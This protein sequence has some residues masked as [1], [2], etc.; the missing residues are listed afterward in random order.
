MHADREIHPAARRAA[1]CLASLA[2]AIA[3]VAC[4]GSGGGGS[5]TPPAGTTNYTVGVTVN[6]VGTGESFVFSLA[7]QNVSV[8]QGGVSVKFAQA[9]ATGAS[10]TVNQT[11]GPRTCTLSANRTGAIAAANVEV[12][13]NCGTVPGTSQLNGTLRGPVGAQVV[14]QNNGG[15]NLTATVVQSAGVTDHYD[16]TAF[17]FPTLLADGTAYQVSLFTA[18]ANQTCSV[19]KGASGTVPVTATALRVGC[20]FTY[21]HISRSGNDAVRGTYFESRDPVVGGGNVAIGATTQGY[22]E[23]RFVA[24]VSSAVGLAPGAVSGR[25]QIYWRDNLTGETRLV[26]ATA[27]GVEGNG[28]S[29]APAIS[30]DG[31]AVAFESTA[32]N[33][34]AGDTNGVSDIF[35]WSAQDPAGGVERLSVGPNGVQADAASYEPTVSG[36]GRVVA[37]SSGASNLT[38]GV[39]GINTINVYRRDVIAGTNTLISANGAGTGV[40]GSKPAL[41]EDGQRLAFYSFASN[42]TAGDGNGLWDIFVYDHSNGT[43]TRVS[44]TNGGGERNQGTESASRVVAPAISGD[45]RYVA[46]STTASNMVAGDTNGMQDVFVVDTQTGAVVRASVSSAGVQGNADSPVGQGERVALSYDGTWVAFSTNATTLGSLAG[47]VLMHNRVTGETRVVSNQGNGSVG[48]AAM[49]RS[50][51]YVVFGANGQLDSRFASSGLF[52][53]F[54]GVARS[55]WWVD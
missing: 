21:D 46:Y 19:Y 47:N 35:G 43:R 6:A 53:R 37:F 52:S 14:L 11:S 39:S 44:L 3:L 5:T 4:G 7:A 24:F 1:A 38:P 16:E 48:P 28:D 49:S 26:S 20:E 18:P 32:S 8:T 2:S 27:A 12:T 45:G 55:W 10:Y 29:W 30:A 51:A 36:D 40:G 17:T 25:R 22:G 13:A 42:I 50:A 23:G 41:S 34:V 33:L 15:S 54:T 9:L 31:L